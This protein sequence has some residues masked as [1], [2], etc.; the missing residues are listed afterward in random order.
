MLPAPSDVG[1]GDCNAKRRAEAKLSRLGSAS[2]NTFQN[3]PSAGTGSSAWLA[4]Q[5]TSLPVPME[6]DVGYAALRPRMELTNCDAHTSMSASP[7]ERAKA[8]TSM[9]CS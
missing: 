5:Y 6:Y 9:L 4:S 2:A 7:S 8:T 1:A 3:V